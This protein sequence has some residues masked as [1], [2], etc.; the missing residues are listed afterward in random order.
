MNIQKNC[1]AC[2]EII[3]VRL[4]DH[5]RG[6]GRFCD[7]ECAATYKNGNRPGS[8]NKS[9]AKHS[10]WA[11][12]KLAERAERYGGEAPPKAPSIKE[13]IGHK[14]KVRPVYHSPSNCRKCGVPI[15]GPGLC[16]ECDMHE[17]AMAAD[18]AG[19]DGHK[20]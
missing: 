6:W 13:Q 17:E 9:F 3:S 7:K 10:P 12:R 1:A 14:P 20:S 5:K 8:V 18:E 15:N 11:S 16:D 4:A 19:W 2:G